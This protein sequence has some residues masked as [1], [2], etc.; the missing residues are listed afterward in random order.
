MHH[1]R[2]SVRRIFLG[3]WLQFDTTE[4]IVH[5]NLFKN[6]V[7]LLDIGSRTDII[8]I[9]VHIVRHVFMLAHQR[10]HRSYRLTDS[11]VRRPRS[12]SAQRI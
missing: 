1:N 8:M 6:R 3:R 10:C 7:C 5:Q 2:Q 4:A 12:M 11:Q 9:L